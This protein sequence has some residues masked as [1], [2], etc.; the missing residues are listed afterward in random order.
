VLLALQETL[1]T[2]RYADSAKKIVNKAV[3]NED[4]TSRL[5]REL[6]E[7]IQVLKRELGQLRSGLTSSSGLGTVDEDGEAGAGSGGGGAGGSGGDGSGA[8]GDGGGGGEGGG[9]GGGGAGGGGAEEADRRSKLVSKL[10]RAAAIASMLSSI[11]E[12]DSF[13]EV[14]RCVIAVVPRLVMLGATARGRALSD[15][16]LLETTP[17]L[18]HSRSVSSPVSPVTPNSGFQHLRQALVDR[19]AESRESTSK[20][21]MIRMTNMEVRCCCRG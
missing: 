9:G 1:S 19:Q 15:V 16:R 12:S 5:I 13:G 14:L 7:E 6:R 20:K 10:Q 2:L 3:V 21:T 18:G 8:G 11:T 17:R 4:S